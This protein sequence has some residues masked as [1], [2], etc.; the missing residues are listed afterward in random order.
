MDCMTVLCGLLHVLSLAVLTR[1]SLLMP[2]CGICGTCN[3]VQLVGLYLPPFMQHA[4]LAIS[5][6]TSNSLVAPLLFPAYNKCHLRMSVHPTGGGPAS[7]QQPPAARP[8]PSSSP[9]H[10]AKYQQQQLQQQLLSVSN[11]L[12]SWCLKSQ[13]G[14]LSTVLSLQP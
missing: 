10:L 4:V 7:Q 11:L 5:T 14:P 6:S 9:Q 8:P 13:T 12:T 1:G 2:T 3:S